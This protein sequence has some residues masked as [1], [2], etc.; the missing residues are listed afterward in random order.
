MIDYYWKSVGIIE[1]SGKIVYKTQAEDNEGHVLKTYRYEY[2]GG[3]WLENSRRRCL[4]LLNR[5]FKDSDDTVIFAV[6]GNVLKLN[7]FIVY[8][9]QKVT[10]K[11]MKDER[12]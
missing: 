2:T 9:P 3:H 6:S 7:N 5:K 12:L 10:K 11:G 4:E 1:S 8:G